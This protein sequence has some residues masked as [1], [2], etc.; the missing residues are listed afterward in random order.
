VVPDTDGDSFCDAID[1]C[2]TVSDPSQADSD[3]DGDGDA[4]DI[5]TNTLPSFADR[6]KVIIGKLLTPPGDDTL[7]LKGRCIPFQETPAIDPTANGVRFVM[8]DDLGGTPLDVTIP[9]GAYSTVT[10]AGWK[11]H[12]FPTGMTAQYKNDGTIL[13]LINGI[14]KVKFVLKNGLGIT[15]FSLTGKGGGYPVPAGGDPIKVTFIATPPIGAGGQC[16]E[17]LFPG[18]PPVPSCSFVG[19]GATLR[20]K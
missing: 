3:N 13:P 17:M 9:G 7:K 18:P 16:C 14:K 15:K 20:C 19:G 6:S 1:D 5:C 12:T 2:P 4:C 10:K 8:Q 11:S